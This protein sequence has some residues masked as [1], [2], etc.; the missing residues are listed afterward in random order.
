MNTIDGTYSYYLPPTL[1][2][3]TPIDELSNDYLRLDGTSLMQGDLDM[4]THNIKNLADATAP[5]EAINLGQ[6]TTTLGNYVTI[7]TSQT[8]SG[9]KIFLSSTA[10]RPITLTRTT[11]TN[12]LFLRWNTLDNT[13]RWDIGSNANETNFQIRRIAGALSTPI[14]NFDTNQST[15][16]KILNMNNNKIINVSD[17]VDANDAVNLSQLTALGSNYLPLAGGT[18]SGNINMNTNQILNVK[19]IGVNTNAPFSGVHILDDYLRIEDTATINSININAAQGGS[20]YINVIQ[21][22]GLL[23]QNINDPQLDWN[24]NFNNNGLSDCYINFLK[25]S[26]LIN[27]KGYFKIWSGDAT[28][29]AILF[30]PRGS[31]YFHSTKAADQ[32]LIKLGIRTNNPQEALDISGNVRINNKL[33]FGNNN[34]YIDSSAGFLDI[35]A[36]VRIL[37][38][39]NFSNNILLDSSAGW[40]DISGSVKVLNKLSVINNTLE[41]GRFN[42]GTEPSTNL[43]DGALI[44]NT[45][46]DRVKARINGQFKPLVILEDVY[47]ANYQSNKYIVPAGGTDT[48]CNIQFQKTGDIIHATFP[49]LIQYNFN[50]AGTITLQDNLNI[51]YRPVAVQWIPIMVVNN[52]VRQTGVINISTGG[53]VV[54]YSNNAGNFGNNP[55]NQNG[56]DSF[57]ITYRTADLI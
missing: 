30:D 55:A 8:I 37:N 32:N 13:I 4:N 49:A 11:S 45:Q 2:G 54:I 42:N 29:H 25:N 16:Y 40:L 38:K 9:D 28:N 21:S 48:N 57:T 24:F 14:F 7:D 50:T 1:D 22:N 51:I 52:S 34:L 47:Y 56:F 12:P 44:Y 27:G 15:S 41:L 26:N 20:H 6:L 31:S 17:G 36:N 39:L 46:I 5:D 35:S 33:I 10:T 3:L 19:Y 23:Y 53:A 43:N 18:M